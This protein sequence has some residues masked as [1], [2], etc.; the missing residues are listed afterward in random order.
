MSFEIKKTT[1]RLTRGD[2]LKAYI[3][4]VDQNGDPYIPQEGDSIRFAMKKH[5]HDQM[6]LCE[7]EIP[8]DT[9]LLKLDPEDTKKLEFGDYVYDIQLTNKDGEVYT[10]ITKGEIKITE[11]VD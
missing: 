6:V 10:F 9:L 4:I 7:K 2:T 8:T 3:N 1:I 5:Y 11:E